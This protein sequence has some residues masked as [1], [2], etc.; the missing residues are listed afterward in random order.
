MHGQ[1]GVGVVAAAH[2]LEGCEC[3]LIRLIWYLGLALWLHLGLQALLEL[4]DGWA[5]EGRGWQ[6]T[7]L[8]CAT[9]ESGTVAV[10]ALANNFAT[11]HDDRAMAVV[12]G[13]E[14][15]LSKAEGQVGVV[16]GRHLEGW[17]SLSGEIVRGDSK[18]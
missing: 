5:I 4:G 6:Y 14:I 12:Q 18:F 10:E 7:G 11:T 1:R 17:I 8:Q 16:S 2:G 13:R 15:G 9:V 3:P